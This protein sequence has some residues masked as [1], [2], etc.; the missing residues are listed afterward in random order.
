MHIYGGMSKRAMA[1][2]V[3]ARQK[4]DLIDNQ[5]VQRSSFDWLLENGHME[6]QEHLLLTPVKRCLINRIMVLPRDFWS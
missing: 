4:L 5:E 2:L 1:V 3:E 6:I